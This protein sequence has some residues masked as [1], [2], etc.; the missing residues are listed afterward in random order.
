[1][2]TKTTFMEAEPP[3]L[4]EA[5]AIVGGYVEIVYLPDGSQML[6]DED[7]ISKG[8][9]VNYSASMRAGPAILG[10]VLILTGRALWK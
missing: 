10:D 8:L 7:G 9:E 2:A 5:Q 3:T 1:M 4:E 6:V